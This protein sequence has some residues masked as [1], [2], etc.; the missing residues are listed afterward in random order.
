MAVPALAS[1]GAEWSLILMNMPAQDR[2][3]I[4]EPFDPSP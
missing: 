2:K 1:A 4:H 3:N